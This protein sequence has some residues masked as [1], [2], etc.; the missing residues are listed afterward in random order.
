MEKEVGNHLTTF[1]KNSN[2]HSQFTD[3]E[4]KKEA[5]ES[6]DHIKNKNQLHASTNQYH[7]YN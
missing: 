4:I 7:N 2:G 1:P 3:I 5:V 6:Y